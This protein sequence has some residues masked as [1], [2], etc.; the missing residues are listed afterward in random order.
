[1]GRPRKDDRLLRVQDKMLNK[2]L[3]EEDPE[4]MESLL[5]IYDILLD[6]IQKSKSVKLAKPNV[7]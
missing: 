2:L 1:M 4:N 6:I 5:V 3:K 7:Q